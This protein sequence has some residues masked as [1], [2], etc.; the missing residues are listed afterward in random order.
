MATRRRGTAYE[1]LG[2][3]RTCTRDELKKQYA[4]ALKRAH[5]DKGGNDV[6][7]H[8][9]QKAYQTVLKHLSSRRPSPSGEAHAENSSEADG[10][11]G[12]DWVPAEVRNGSEN[13]MAKPRY[14]ATE[15][16]LRGNQSFGEGR[17]GD[18]VKHYTEAL[19]WTPNES[20]LYCNRSAAWFEMGEIDKALRDATR[21]ASISPRYVKARYRCALA[22]SALKRHKEAI[23]EMRLAADLSFSSGEC[24]GALCRIEDACS[25][26]S[27]R[28]NLGGHAD[29]VQSL[30]WRPRGS[31]ASLARPLL[32]TCSLD[33]TVRLWCGDSGIPIKVSRD[34]KDK[35][36]SVRWSRDGEQLVSLSLD[37]TVRVWE[38][39]HGGEVTRKR[40]LEGH[41]GRATSSCYG[42]SGGRDVLITSSTDCTARVWD[43]ASGEACEKVLSGH[44]QMVTWADFS[45]DTKILATASAD[46]TF[47]L[48]DVGEGRCTQTVDW[49]SG[50]VNLCLFVRVEEDDLLVTCHFDVKRETSRLLVWNVNG[51]QGW[52]DGKLV[53]HVNHF[54]GFRGKITCVD[55]T[56]SEDS[57]V[58]LAAGCSDGTVRVFDLACGSGLYD[59]VDQHTPPAGSTTSISCLSFSPSGDKLAT[60][61]WDGKVHIWNAEDGSHTV[62]FSGHTGKICCLGWNDEGTKLASGGND[63]FVKVWDV[64]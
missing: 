43:L 16:K 44:S 52:A 49:D 20:T 54:E 36:T 35:V 45:S 42:E 64:L 24:K 55:S 4:S 48:W 14:M 32:A 41:A 30:A 61:G 34:H 5:P 59:L 13:A 1:V 31:G 12:Q 28:L 21:A 47:K 9:V 15:A 39:C 23:S 33:G 25:R 37:K 60:C 22:Y 18:A 50:A 63:G 11:R 29:T 53:A 58:L 27:L 38:V 46:N 17:Y 8:L 10:G 3:S 6:E 51:K 56:V 26:D 62:T 40:V 2:L 7:F 19:N 57:A